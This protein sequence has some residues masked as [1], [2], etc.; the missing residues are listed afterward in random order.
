VHQC[1]WVD[2]A[3]D[4]IELMFLSV[5]KIPCVIVPYR[6]I[7]VFT[8]ARYVRLTFDCNLGFVCCEFC[9]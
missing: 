9:R 6:R 2:L 3:S 5:L 1:T 7:S 4:S 8:F